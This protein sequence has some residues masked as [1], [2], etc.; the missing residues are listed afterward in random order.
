MNQGANNFG[1][2][3]ISFFFDGFANLGNS[4]EDGR[5]WFE[6]FDQTVKRDFPQFVSGTATFVPTFRKVMV[7]GKEFEF[8]NLSPNIRSALGR[9]LYGKYLDAI[10]ASFENQ[11][12]GKVFKFPFG[13]V[14]FAPFLMRRD[15][16]GGAKLQNGINCAVCDDAHRLCVVEDELFRTDERPGENVHDDGLHLEN[17]LELLP[18]GV[19][20]FGKPFD[21]F[22]FFL[23][24]F[25]KQQQQYY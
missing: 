15:L 1:V 5:W 9:K 22:V 3:A 13:K 23:F 12:G 24:Y 18:R 7:D 2:I 25:K 19:V 10:F 8:N 16:V 17:V 20:D 14:R 21:K 11:L 6:C 4:Y